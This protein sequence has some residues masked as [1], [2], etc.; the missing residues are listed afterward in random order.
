MGPRGVRGPWAD[1]N[2]ER[3]SRWGGALRGSPTPERPPRSER[4]G[5][6]CPAL[7]RA[8]RAGTLTLDAQPQAGERWMPVVS[9]SPDLRRFVTA[10]LG[11]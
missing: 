1:E 6:C 8:K 2:R 5:V 3:R 11:H 4:M 7:T 10:A 9:K